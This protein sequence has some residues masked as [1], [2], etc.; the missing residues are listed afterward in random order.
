MRKVHIDLNLLRSL[1]NKHFAFSFVQWGNLVLVNCLQ[2][3]I[4]RITK[5]AKIFTMDD[6]N[7]IKPDKHDVNI[8][9]RS[10]GKRRAA[11]NSQHPIP[12]AD[13]SLRLSRAH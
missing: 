9:N 7:S 3:T 2:T 1:K 11:I 8:A 10:I 4:I 5:V 6:K 12:E 13:D